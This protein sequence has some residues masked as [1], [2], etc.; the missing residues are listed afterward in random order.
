MMAYPRIM[1]RLE[2]NFPKP[3]TGEM[4]PYPTVVSVTIAQ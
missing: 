1:T 3:V 4:S 2:K